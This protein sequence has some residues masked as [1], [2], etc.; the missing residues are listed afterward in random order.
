M[1]FEALFAVIFT[2]LDPDLDLDLDP[3]A[4]LD[5]D[6]IRIRNTGI[7]ESGFPT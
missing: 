3:Q 2:V 7:E 5:P 4:Q 1:K 6:P